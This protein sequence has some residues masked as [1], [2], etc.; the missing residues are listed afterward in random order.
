V[1]SRAFAVLVLIMSAN[2]LGLLDREIA[3][4]RAART[5]CKRATASHK[6]SVA[7]ASRLVLHGARRNL[8]K[9]PIAL[10]T[11][12]AFSTNQRKEADL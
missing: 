5:V 8:M 10:V 4:F 3:G 1:S 6:L 2:L 9:R 12:A 11:L 7:V